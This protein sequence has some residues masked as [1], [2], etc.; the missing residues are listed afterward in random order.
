[1][2]TN[3]DQITVNGES[4]F[5]KNDFTNA[6]FSPDGQDP[7][8]LSKVLSFRNIEDNTDNSLANNRTVILPEDPKVIEQREAAATEQQNKKNKGFFN[9]LF[10]RGN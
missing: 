4:W 10:N 8:N 2:H 6:L 1:M 5:R 7:R 9:G 3:L